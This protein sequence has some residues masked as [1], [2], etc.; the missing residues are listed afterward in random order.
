MKISWISIFTVCLARSIVLWLPRWHSLRHRWSCHESWR[1]WGVILRLCPHQLILIWGSLVLRE[2]MQITLLKFEP[3]P[4]RCLHK[5]VLIEIHISQSLPRR[6]S[7]VGLHAPKFPTIQ[8]L[9]SLEWYRAWGWDQRLVVLVT[10]SPS[11]QSLILTLASHRLS[12]LNVP[13][14]DKDGFWLSRTSFCLHHICLG[15]QC[16][17]SAVK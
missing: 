7:P 9:I 13:F 2:R 10:R 16:H 3:R 14:W 17:E 12:I 1:S 4:K 11:F 5:A 6:H 8:F 15:Q